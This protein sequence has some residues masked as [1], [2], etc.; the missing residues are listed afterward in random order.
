M[1]LEQRQADFFEFE[2]SLVY[3]GS[4]STARSTQKN[5]ASGKRQNTKKEGDS[6]TMS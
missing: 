1:N 6:A 5:P 3:T 4:S 2:T